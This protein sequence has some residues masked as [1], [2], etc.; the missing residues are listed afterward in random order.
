MNN[1]AGGN[2]TASHVNPSPVD[3]EKYPLSEYEK[4]ALGEI[5]N[6]CMGT[7][8]TTLSSLLGNRC[9]LRSRKFPSPAILTR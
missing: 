4:D 7:S 3:Y 8:A 6:I 2:D 5:G 9:P 1:P